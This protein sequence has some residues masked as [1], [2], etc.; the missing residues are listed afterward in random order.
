[1]GE[2][3]Q[4][5]DTVSEVHKLITHVAAVATV[6]RWNFAVDFDADGAVNIAVRVPGREPPF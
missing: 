1:M 4:S 5:G 3:D 6:N 2:D